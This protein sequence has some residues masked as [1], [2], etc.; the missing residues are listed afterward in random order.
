MNRSKALIL[1]D[2]IHLISVPLRAL[3]ASHSG[4][5]QLLGAIMLNVGVVADALLMMG[6][7]PPDG[8][9]VP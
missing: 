2:S 8:I 3:T 6:W 4:L 7:T 1:A 5:R 9:E